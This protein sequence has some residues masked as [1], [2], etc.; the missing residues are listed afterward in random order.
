MSSVSQK[1]SELRQFSFVNYR[2]KSCYLKIVK[3]QY[4][5]QFLSYG[6][7]F[8]PVIINLIGFKITFSNMGAHSAPSL[9]SGGKPKWHVAENLKC[10]P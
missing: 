4:L 3:S 9:I 10:R 8:L 7:D 2:K 5:S 1:L 6:P